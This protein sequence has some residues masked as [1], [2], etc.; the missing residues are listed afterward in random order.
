LTRWFASVGAVAHVG[1]CKNVNAVAV[2]R[3]T[4][5]VAATTLTDDPAKRAKPLVGSS[6]NEKLGSNAV[7]STPLMGAVGS[8]RPCLS[9]DSESAVATSVIVP[10]AHVDVIVVSVTTGFVLD[11]NE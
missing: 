2:A 10:F 5:T 9:S 4:S 11:G 6:E 8:V 7:P 1:A 3:A